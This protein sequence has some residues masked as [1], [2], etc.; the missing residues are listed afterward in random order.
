MSKV[1]VIGARRARQGIGE[2]VARWFHAAGAEVCAI[3]GTEPETLSEAQDN[4]SS[5]YGIECRGYVSLEVALDEES[6]DIVAICSPIA[7]HRNQLL[8]VAEAGLDCLCEKP[9]WWG[10]SDDRR[11]ETETLVDS[12]RTKNNI[13]G[14]LTQWPFTLPAFDAIHPEARTGPIES[15]EMLLSPISRGPR[16]LIDSLSHPIS[17]L[18]AL[19]GPGFVENAE[20]RYGASGRDDMTLEFEY[21]HAHG[22]TR[23]S[24]HLHTCPEPPRPAGFTINGHQIRREIDLPD[25]ELYFS[26]GDRRV[27]VEDPVK[28]LVADFLQ[29]VEQRRSDDRR[30]LVESV[31]NLETLHAAGIAASSGQPRE[32]DA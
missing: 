15:F 31:V 7:N 12:F 2:F 11:A 24:V 16:M 14:L 5:R 19:V 29:R 26:N 30:L 13:L 9:L 23:S 28:L 21:R 3:V 32:A 20:A 8:Q 4:L 25:Y 6:A 1:I 22:T 10:D 18:Q 17:L 27:P